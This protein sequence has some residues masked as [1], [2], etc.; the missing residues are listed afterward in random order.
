MLRKKL[1][2]DE[3]Q[4]EISDLRSEIKNSKFKNTILLLII[5]IMILFEINQ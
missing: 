4:E 2:Q 3:L 5:F 1:N